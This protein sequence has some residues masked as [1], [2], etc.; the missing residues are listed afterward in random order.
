MSDLLNSV[1]NAAIP[2]EPALRP[3]NSNNQQV[4]PVYTTE[5]VIK[6]SVKDSYSENKSGM[7]FNYNSISN[8]TAKMLAANESVSEIVKRALFNPNTI[9]L[10]QANSKDGNLFAQFFRDFFFT[11]EQLMNLL[12]S[13]TQNTIFQGPLFD[14]LSNMYQQTNN[15][16]IQNGILNVL[17]I[18]DLYNSQN[19]T[20]T[21]LQYSLQ[22]LLPFFSSDTGTQLNQVFQQLSTAIEQQEQSAMLAS[23]RA[24]LSLLSDLAAANKDNTPL[25]NSIMLAVHQLTRLDQTEYSQLTR[26]LE[27]LF[28]TLQQYTDVSPDQKD[29]LFQLLHQQLQYRQ[30]QAQQIAHQLAASFEQ[31]LAKDSPIGL[32]LIT[33]SMLSSI[34]MNNSVMLPLIYGFVPLQLA[35]TF[36]F[37]EFW[38]KVDRKEKEGKQNEQEIKATIFFTV[39]SSVLGSFQGTIETLGQN[40]DITLESPES[41]IGLMQGLSTHLEPVLSETGYRLKNLSIVPLTTPKKAIDVFGRQMLKEAYINVRV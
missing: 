40:M 19:T 14:L 27:Q 37:S 4:Q 38:A 25:R 5:K 32:Q 12:N 31:G 3:D 30:E 13:Q 21:N 23:R 29:A 8:R 26:S 28:G 6:T 1:T 9:S 22:Q 16:E 2:K 36:L 18:F 39:E 7:E 17:K 11:Q 10:T 20:L 41:F 35:N 33:S 24:M 34:L 15:Q